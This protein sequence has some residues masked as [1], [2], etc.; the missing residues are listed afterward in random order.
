MLYIYIYNTIYNTPYGAVVWVRRALNRPK[1]RFS[2]RAGWLSDG[3]KAEETEFKMPTCKSY[4]RRALR[5]H[6]EAA[7]PALLMERTRRTTACS[8]C[9]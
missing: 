9:G 2:A 1:R 8:S 3:S 5:E 4:L 7:H 6:V